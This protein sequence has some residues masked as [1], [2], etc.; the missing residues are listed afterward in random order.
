VGKLI[1]DKSFGDDAIDAIDGVD[2]DTIQVKSSTLFSLQ[3]IF[4][5]LPTVNTSTSSLAAPLNIPTPPPVYRSELPMA[6]INP[7]Q[8]QLH[9]SHLEQPLLGDRHNSLKG[10]VSSLRQSSA[11][12][13]YATT[14]VMAVAGTC[15]IFGGVLL[16]MCGVFSMSTALK[17]VGGGFAGL[18]GSVAVAGV[19]DC[20]KVHPIEN[21]CTKSEKPPLEERMG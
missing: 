7:A 10:C 8:G 11:V 21:C 2:N 17:V 18:C 6:Q 9:I 3:F 20:V 15:S 4:T 19:A 12:C 16:N 14:G 13:C 1:R 5:M